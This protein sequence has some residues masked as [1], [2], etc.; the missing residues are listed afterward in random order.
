MI[1]TLGMIAR[2]L[3]KLRMQRTEQAFQVQIY[4]MVSDNGKKT[5]HV[6]WCTFGLAI[7][8]WTAKSYGAQQ[9]TAWKLFRPIL[10]F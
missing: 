4:L 8:E 6:L 1:M 3:Y 10:G 2:Q 5:E 9:W 7:F